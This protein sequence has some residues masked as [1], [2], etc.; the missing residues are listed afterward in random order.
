MRTWVEEANIHWEAANA[1]VVAA[2]RHAE[3]LQVR[4]NVAVVDRGAHL[5]AFLRMP[6]AP[7]HSIDIAR[8][9]A[10]TAVSFGFATSDWAQALAA[11]SETTRAG[12]VGR[13][14]MAMI[15]GGVPIE[16]DGWIIGAIGVSGASEAQDEAIARAGAAAAGQQGGAH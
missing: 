13:P 4:V 14:G 16:A 15:G 8:D 7:F 1:A 3:Q 5:A 12:L 11:M 9:K 6:G 2:V 10:G